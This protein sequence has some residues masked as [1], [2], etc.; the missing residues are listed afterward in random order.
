MS[1]LTSCDRNVDSKWSV[2]PSIRC[3]VVGSD[4]DRARAGDAP[5]A[6]LRE[7]GGQRGVRPSGWAACGVP[8]DWGAGG[9]GPPPPPPE[10]LRWFS[11]TET[12]ALEAARGALDRLEVVALD[13]VDGEHL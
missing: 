2:P 9:G 6:L 4:T 10:C 12:S 7:G 11:R 1:P 3:V 13:R 8:T 5:V